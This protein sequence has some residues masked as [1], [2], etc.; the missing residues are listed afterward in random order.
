MQ[1]SQPVS[2]TTE[3]VEQYKKEQYDAQR[4]TSWVWDENMVSW[5]A[6]K[7]YPEDGFPYIWDEEKLEWVAFP[8]YPRE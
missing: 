1:N 2:P 8:D 4:P 7:S 5:K 3:E 6:P